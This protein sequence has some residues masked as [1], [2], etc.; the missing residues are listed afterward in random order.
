MSDAGDGGGPLSDLK[1]L[2][3]G[4]VVAGPYATLMLSDLGAEVVKVER[5]DRGDHMRV[6]GETGRAIFTMMNRDKQSVALDLTSDGDREAFLDLVSESDAVVENIAPGAM[7][8]LDLGYQRLRERNKS[9]IYV[10]IKGYAPEGP[11]AER[12]ATDPILQAMSGLMAATGYPETPPARAG[13]SV[14]DIATAQ[15]AVLATL[16]ALRRRR[17]TGVG[18]YLNVPLFRTG[19]ALMGYWLAYRQ[20]FGESPKRM[21][22][23]H[24]L[25][26]P[27]DVFPTAGGDHVFIAVVT[28]VHWQ[29]LQ[30]ELGLSLPY[31]TLPERLENRA[32][33]R[34]E[35]TTITTEYSRSELVDRLLRAGVPAA[36]VN[37]VSDLLAD[38]HLEAVD[39][40]TRV[41]TREADEVVVPWTIPW[42]QAPETSTNPPGLDQDRDEVLDPDDM[43]TDDGSGGSKS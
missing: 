38:P 25:Y 13:T 15:N 29:S 11:Y 16:V 12:A 4:H 31:P 9:L 35:I 20:Q 3:V 5:P 19:V 10:S 30:D 17:Q 8:R 23:S 18:E 40:F 2:E 43:D 33:I 36:P 41:S 7:D 6:A 34:N 21:G 22:A 28:D 1:V 37:D 32:A 14:V 24:S 39:A 26:A 42:Q 27:Y